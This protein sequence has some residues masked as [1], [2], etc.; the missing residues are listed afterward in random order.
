MK[1]LLSDLE[2]AAQKGI[3][4]SDQAKKLW[5]H[6]ES[7]RPDQSRFQ[8][9]HVLYYF[10]GIL[11]LAS[12]SWFLTNAWSDGGALMAISG[13]FAFMY[14]VAGHTLWNKQNLKIPGGLLITAA[15]GLTPVFIYGFQK[16]TDL[17]PQ[18]APGGYRDYHIWIKGSWL[19]MELGT[20]IAAMIALR[21]YRFAFITFPLALTLWY[22]SMDLTPLIFGKYN[23]T[24]EEK[25]IF[26]CIFGF[27]MLLGSFY[28][29]KKYKEI[30]FAFW[31]Y[32]F[33]MI[34]YWGGLSTMD[35]DSE[36]NKLIYCLLNVSFIILSVYLRRRIF[37]VFGTLGVLG[38]L[39]H[40]ASKVFEDSYAF[41]IVL[42]LLG[43]CIVYLGVL[44]QKNRNKFE[45]F[46]ES[47]LPT[48]LMKWRPSERA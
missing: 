7:L 20:I 9:L 29:D 17:W 25:Q 45:S 16:M 24:F 23:Y 2:S 13:F 32:L 40:L 18:E 42:A 21:F 14:V 47:S 5:E 27:I 35:S 12:M 36:L 37:I 28:V 41:P 3:I 26:S 31:T 48:V 1:I 33:G 34:A 43:L 4:S 46:V 6:L 10:G 8:A 15:V 38:Y 39:G 44:Y 11:I 30:D 19:F 22:M